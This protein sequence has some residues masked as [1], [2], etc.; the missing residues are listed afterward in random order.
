MARDPNSPASRREGLIRKL[1]RLCQ[2]K[3]PATK[4]VST[5]PA[6]NK[7]FV[8]R[9]D[10]LLA[11]RGIFES[12]GSA[13]L[14]CSI[15][16]LGGIGKTELASSYAHA[17]AKEY[18]GGRFLIICE[19]KRSLR[20]AVLAQ[21]DFADLFRYDVPEEIRADPNSHFAAIGRCLKERAETS[22]QI[23]LIFDH[24]TDVALFKSD[25]VELLTSAGGNLHILA[26]SR[27]A[28]P[29]RVKL[30][31]LML[32]ELPE[33]DALALLERHR[34]FAND[35]ERHG[36]L[37]IVKQLGGF[38]LAVEL[39]GA[40][41]AAHAG[42]SNY[43]ALADGLQLED[44]DE[45]AGD[46]EIQLRSR[47]ERGL[48]AILAPV[49]KELDPTERCVLEY[50][51]LLPQEGAPLPW[52]K[53]LLTRSFPSF[54][55]PADD[56]ADWMEPVQRLIRLG[57][58][59]KIDAAI[60][61]P[62]FVRLHAL[63]RQL[64]SKDWSDFDRQ[65]RQDAITELIV[66]RDTVLRKTE[67]WIEA[68]W[69]IE[70]LTALAPIWD[71][72]K[73][74]LAAWLFGQT[75]TFWLELGDWAQAESAA[76]RA[77]EIYEKKYGPN[78]TYVARALNNLAQ[79][80]NRTNRLAEAEPLMRRSLAIDE[81]TFGPDHP[82]VARVL[83]NLAGLLMATYR[84]A[85]A[86]PIY[87]RVL[88]IDQK[89]FGS[90]HPEVARGLNNLANLLRRTNRLEEAEKLARWALDIVENA[91]GAENRKL[92]TYL[93]NLAQLLSDTGRLAESEQIM[94][95]VIAIDEKNLEADH[96]SASLHLS[97]LAVMLTKGHRPKEAESLLQRAL[98]FDEKRFG[99]NHPRVASVLLNLAI[100]LKGRS[101]RQAE[102]LMRRALAIQEK[103]L[104]PDHPDV[105][106]V[107]NTLAVFLMK[108]LRAN[109]AEPLLRRALVIDEKA[110][111]P[112]HPKIALRLSNLGT[113][114]KNQKRLSEAEPFFRRRLEIYR[115]LS[116]PTTD[117]HPQLDS[118]ITQY[119]DLLEAMGK[120]YAEVFDQLE[121]MCAPY[122]IGPYIDSE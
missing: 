48:T 78:H 17:Y 81:E 69:E 72:M 77:L 49:R 55:S 73:H 66:Q 21:S 84:L 62:A 30:S 98:A 14:I 99:P 52:L 111:G 10:E 6:F 59:A 106:K 27:L 26:T 51:L 11:L 109:E 121:T 110:V 113:L 103:N 31:P 87:R 35:S 15:H 33:P 57:L 120:S 29:E 89:H 20:N 22:G 3:K 40:W 112:D 54:G 82:K 24:I 42:D 19:G 38:A 76:R 1:R 91:Y 7:N 8:G 83:S 118:A 67:N 100:V 75:G 18:P 41:L 95:R 74:P 94:R 61:R 53:A 2:A 97:N 32:G 108:T 101:R 79:I 102:P 71:E 105:A 65:S 5:V 96:P 12:D 68:R 46:D 43:S 104:G 39:V 25:Q 115:K 47:H 107:L 122:G 64:I 16:G 28:A 4:G 90:E 80:L 92:T 88:V 37:S 9:I 119:S 36:A 60:N 56:D 13:G 116:P 86:E 23:L 63:V 58:L 117:R 44:L 93:N 50:A 70:P 85:E 45:M 114:L 34:P